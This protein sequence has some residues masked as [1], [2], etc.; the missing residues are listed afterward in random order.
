MG[1]VELQNRGLQIACAHPEYLDAAA[2]SPNS[3]CKKIC[4]SI[5]RLRNFSIYLH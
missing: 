3:Y 2:W 4:R 1:Y 5:E